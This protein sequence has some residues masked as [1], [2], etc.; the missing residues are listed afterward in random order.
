MYRLHGKLYE[1]TLFEDIEFP[2]GKVYEDTAIMYQLF[3]KA[4][5]LGFGNKK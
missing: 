2:K 5:K 1:K 3:E 4:K